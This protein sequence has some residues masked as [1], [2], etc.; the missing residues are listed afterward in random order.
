MDVIEAAKEHFKYLG[1][2]DELAR[3]HNFKENKLPNEKIG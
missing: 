1:K 2:A 3:G